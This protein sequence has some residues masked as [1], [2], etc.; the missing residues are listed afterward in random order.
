MGVKV[1][2]KRKEKSKMAKRPSRLESAAYHEAGPAVASY[3]L[4]QR[5]SY[6]TVNPDEDS[7]GHIVWINLAKFNPEVDDLEKIRKPLEKMIFTGQAG[8]AAERLFRG[9]NNWIGSNSDVTRAL[10]FLFYLVGTPEEAEAY[11]NWLFIRIG[12][13]LSRDWNWA[14]VEAL[15]NALMEQKK[16]GYK[17]AREIIKN[18][19][20][21]EFNKG[22]KPKKKI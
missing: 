15:A 10:D 21:A 19:I 9:R 18:A 20:E 1:R 22:P 8:H 16:I 7:L 11:F 14:A 13:L 6:L 4:N 12:N 17:K 2:K 3:I 5:F